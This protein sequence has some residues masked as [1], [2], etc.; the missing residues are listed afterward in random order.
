MHYF[1]IDFENVSSVHELENIDGIKKGGKAIV[2]YTKIA[3][4]S[5]LH[6]FANCKS[7]I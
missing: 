7:T 3:E 1:L 4:I 2:F 6:R 5:L